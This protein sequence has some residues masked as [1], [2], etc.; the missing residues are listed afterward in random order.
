MKKVPLR[1]SRADNYIP[2]NEE[3]I[4]AFDQIDDKRYKTILKLLAF[5]GARITK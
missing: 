2:T 4:G 5:P 3:V 1:R